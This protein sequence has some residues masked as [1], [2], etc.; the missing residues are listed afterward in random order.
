MHRDKEVKMMADRIISMRTELVAE[1][2][3]LGSK[4]D[5][6]HITNQIGMLLNCEIGE[7]GD[8]EMKLILFCVHL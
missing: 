2:K 5:W 1:L 7:C 4:K 8:Y 3:R 6:S